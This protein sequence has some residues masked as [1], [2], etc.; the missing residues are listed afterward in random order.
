MYIS[1]SPKMLKVF[2]IKEFERLM[3]E[4]EFFLGGVLTNVGTRAY[5]VV[6]PGSHPLTTE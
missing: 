6:A 2:S 4:V 1:G 3:C 5:S